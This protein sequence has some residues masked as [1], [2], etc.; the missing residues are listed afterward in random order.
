M[1]K[2]LIIED[3]DDV[4]ENLKEILELSNYEIITANNGKEGVQTAKTENPDLIICDI[5][6]PVL[7]GYGVLNILSHDPKTSEIPFIFLTARTEL[8]DI[9]KGMNQG[10]DDYITKP[11]D[12]VDLMN[13][14]EVRLKK[15]EKIDK[16]TI[17]NRED[18]DGFLTLAR[19][20]SGL[21]DLI[22]AS[23]HRN[24]KTKDIIFRR[25][26]YSTG[27]FYLIKGKV[28]LYQINSEGKEITTRLLKP[29]DYF[30]YESL[31]SNESHIDGA[32]VL[33]NA[34]V[35]H[36]PKEDFMKLMYT[37][38][39]VT[40]KFIKLLSNNVEEKQKQ[41]LDLAYKT[42]R[43]RVADALVQ[44]YDKYK[45]EEN[46]FVIAIS[47]DDLASIVGTST[48]S[49]IRMLSEF[50]KSGLIQIQGSKIN[51]LEPEKLR[52]APY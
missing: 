42:V 46:S 19:G 18:M 48:E 47:R 32:E 33:E 50:K 38:R 34:E 14:I 8:T 26:E 22:E 49:T 35:C 10:A 6:M 12:E 5:M 1:K 41:L 15:K 52:K 2:I 24:Y 27:L 11:F 39:D 43:K 20:L 25:A 28:K 29:N 37:N 40:A 51:V 16:L 17:S 4:R 21:E 3:S 45:G 36:I 7:D 30:G 44:L 9:R 23:Q 31:L 13:A